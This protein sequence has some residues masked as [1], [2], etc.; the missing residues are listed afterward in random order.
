MQIGHARIDTLLDRRRDLVRAIGNVP[1][2]L[3]G[4]QLVDRG[5]DDQLFHPRVLIDSNYRLWD[6]I[7]Y[8]QAITRALR[9]SRSNQAHA[10]WQN[11][12]LGEPLD[13][14]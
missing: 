3:F 7:S 10:L 13:F 1:V 6:S 2:L 9:R 14:R 11:S 8:V 12:I 5:F 4:D